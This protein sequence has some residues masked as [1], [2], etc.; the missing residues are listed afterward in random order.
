MT[1]QHDRW[2]WASLLAAEAFAAGVGFVVLL[3]LARV[4]GPHGFSSIEYAGAVAG[5]MLVWVRG[6]V[7][8]I[9]HREAARNPNLIAPLTET[10]LVAKIALASLA[11]ALIAV[12]AFVLGEPQSTVLLVAGLIL[13]PSS[14]CLDVGPRATCNF[15]AIAAIQTLR[16]IGLFMVVF[17]L[18]SGP[19]D[20]LLAAGCVVLAE[21]IS[22]LCFAVLHV[23]KY[24]M[25]RLRIRLWAVRALLARG[26][27]TSLGRFGRVFLY[28]AD[29]LILGI[30]LGPSDL[31]PYAAARRVVFAILAIGLVIPS[32]LGP[33]LAKVWS[34]APSETSATLSRITSVLL[35][36]LIAASLG[37]I[38]LAPA[39]MN[40][41]FGSSY[42]SGGLALALFAARLP[43]MMMAAMVTTAL[44]AVRLE[45]AAL[46]TLSVACVLA[47]LFIPIA[48]WIW[49]PIGA[50][51]SML[52]IEFFVSASGW[53]LLGKVGA[54]A[55][56]PTIASADLFGIAAMIFIVMVAQSQPTW[57][58]SLFGAGAFV[59]VRMVVKRIES[60]RPLA[61]VEAAR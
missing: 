17:L 48:S 47:V 27:I 24:R 43:L 18:V 20:S 1:T 13:I 28:A 4:L 25:P 45:S 55:K 61:S 51:W 5:V 6:G 56:Y 14:M 8:T 30:I 36:P 57:A 23:G 35:G 40:D 7:E 37:L 54:A 22:T 2:A 39:W 3:R 16:T 44:V 9:T 42:R 29:L 49:G 53:R 34:S 50:A 33:I 10:L 59:S 46:R 19:K 58:I 11:L 41:L 38:L 32:A 31:G 15:H 12:F 52:A 60:V 26:L 21:T